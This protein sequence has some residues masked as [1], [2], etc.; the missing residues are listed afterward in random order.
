MSFLKKTLLTFFSAQAVCTYGSPFVLLLFFQFYFGK[1]YAQE[2][3]I[4]S[5]SKLISTVPF[6]TFTG[7]VVVI[8]CQLNDDPD[9]LNFIVDTGSGGISLDSSTCVRLKLQPI[10]SDKTIK[11]IARHPPG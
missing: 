8:K 7:G 5:A 4:P 1:A 10:P 6:T 9:S 11:G 3:F 2:Q